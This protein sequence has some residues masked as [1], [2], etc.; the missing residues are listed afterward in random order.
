MEQNNQQSPNSQN[1]SNQNQNSGLMQ[2]VGAVLPALLEHFTGQKI[3]PSGSSPENQLI[4][5][6]LL[7]IQ[8]QILANQQSFNQRLMTL[9]TNASQQFTNLVQQVQ[10]IKSIRLS[11]SRETKAIDYGLEDKN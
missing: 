7:S 5:S 6:Q 4:L 2:L 3:N 10:S 9:E 11:H 8:Q 1:Q